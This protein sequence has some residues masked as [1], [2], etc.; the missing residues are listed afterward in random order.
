MP[1]LLTILEK[2]VVINAI[3]FLLNGARRQL[4]SLNVQKTI[5]KFYFV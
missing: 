2:W 1:G 4:T 5:S 3:A